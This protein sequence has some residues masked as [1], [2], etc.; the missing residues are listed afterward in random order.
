MSIVTL[1]SGGLDSTLLSVLAAEE[2]VAIHPLFIDYGQRCAAQEWAACQAL[3]VKHGLPS[4][5]RM[6]LTGFG[7]VVRSGLTDPALR[8][9]EDAFLPG[10][11]L[12]LLVAAAGY[13]HQVGASAVAIGLLNDEDH[14]F[15]DQTREFIHQSERLLELALG[16]PVKVAT[17]LVQ[18][19]KADVIKL[20]AA[21]GIEGTYSCHTGSQ[22]PCGVCVSCI[23]R[24]NAMAAT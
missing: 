4:P 11:N 18:F 2:G 15:P 10:R 22:E 16:H 5:R 19:R 7:E 13:A 21:H 14:L 3:H 24:Q 6:P 1:V 8:V 23:E 20:A 17:P 9:N 12:L